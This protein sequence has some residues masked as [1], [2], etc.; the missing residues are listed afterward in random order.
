MPFVKYAG[1]IR[2]G[3]P[4]TVALQKFN[5]PVISRYDLLKMTRSHIKCFTLLAVGL[6]GF[7]CKR[8]YTN[9]V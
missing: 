2:E 9:R 1:Q 7:K 3:W 5:Q 4:R 8:Q 6:P